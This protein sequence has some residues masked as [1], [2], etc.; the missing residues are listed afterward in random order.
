MLDHG[1]IGQCLL[2]HVEG[3]VCRVCNNIG[4]IEIKPAVLTPEMVKALTE[5]PDLT[6]MKICN[7]TGKVLN[8][9]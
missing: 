9:K 1:Y 8:V 2:E 4:W 6:Y 7:H 3:E 5:N